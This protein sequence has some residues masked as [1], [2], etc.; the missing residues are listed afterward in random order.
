[1]AA[2][3]GHAGDGSERPHLP[4]VP[5]KKPI[6]VA[7]RVL[8]TEL[9]AVELGPTHNPDEDAVKLEGGPGG[10]HEY[11]FHYDESLVVAKDKPCR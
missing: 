3:D 8:G 2:G 11:G 4:V 5:W 6:F 1:M 7:F 9:F 10:S